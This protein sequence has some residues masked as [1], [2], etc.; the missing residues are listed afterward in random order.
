MLALAFALLFLLAPFVPQSPAWAACPNP[1]EDKAESVSS[2]ADDVVSATAAVA[3]KAVKVAKIADLVAAYSENEDHDA[4]EDDDYGSTLPQPDTTITVRPGIALEI[5]NFGGEITVKTWDKDAIKIAADH[6]LRDKVIIERTGSALRLKVKS[7]RFVPAMIRYRITA[8]RW[9]KL[10]LSGV[11]TDI[12]VEDSHGEVRA[13]T[14]QGDIT[15][16]GSVGFVSLSSIQGEITAQ[17]VRG[18]V[19]ASSVNQ[20]VRLIN[21]VGPIFAESV[22]GGIVIENAESVNGGIDIEGATS[23]SVEASTVN[24]PVTFEGTVS[25]QGY[26]RFATHNGCIDVAMPEASNATLSV[27]TFSG[28]IDSSFPVTLKKV[29]SKRFQTTL[30][31]GKARFEL[32]SFQGTIFLRRPGEARQSCQEDEDKDDDQD[33]VLTGHKV[34]VKEK[35][36][37]V[38]KVKKSEKKKSSGDGDDDSEDGE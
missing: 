1:P 36:E 16:K 19:E 9:M 12:D 26:Y 31:N 17:G 33:K 8:P 3:A 38:E 23:D 20:G 34:T 10:E 30:G 25:D 7:R 27:S 2:W 35:T 28:G 4:E 22:N 21:V 5:E 13:E 14:V 6:S 29:R 18:R 24:G 11:N 37:K 32:E 15:L